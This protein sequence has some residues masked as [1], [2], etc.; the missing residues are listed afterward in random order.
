MAFQGLSPV[1]LYRT[2]ERGLI[3]H[4]KSGN[5]CANVSSHGWT[6]LFAYIVFAIS[7]L[8]FLSLCESAVFTVATATVS[9]PLSGIWWS[10]YRMDIGLHG[11]KYMW[12]MKC[13]SFGSDFA[14]IY[15]PR[16]CV[17]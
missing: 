16:F 14:A 10:I 15:F 11:G 12:C 5:L 6:F 1:E 8:N 13:C 4:F 2:V 3:C 17:T 7:I 9:L